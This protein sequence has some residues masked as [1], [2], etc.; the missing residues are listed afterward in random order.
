MNGDTSGNLTLGSRGTIG[1]EFGDVDISTTT[2]SA[3]W[4]TR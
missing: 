3:D 2:R 4:G 1:R